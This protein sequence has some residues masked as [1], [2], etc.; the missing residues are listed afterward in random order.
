M[1]LGIGTDIVSVK[2]IEQALETSGRQFLEKIFTNVELEYCET[3]THKIEHFA[4]KFAAK[5]AFLKALGFGLGEIGLKMIEIKNE[6]NGKPIIFLHDKAER[7]KV[8]RKINKIF[9]SISHCREY[10][11]ATVIVEGKEND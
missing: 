8:D 6:N 2:R 9:V 7:V 10:A 3:Q 1:I 5:E 4:G 11:T